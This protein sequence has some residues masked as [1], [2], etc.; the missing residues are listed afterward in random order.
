MLASTASS[1]PS[2]GSFSPPLEDNDDLAETVRTFLLVFG[3]LGRMPSGHHQRHLIHSSPPSF[4]PLSLFA[5]EA[6]TLDYPVSKRASA[7]RIESSTI[8]S[9]SSST[10]LRSPSANLLLFIGTPSL[11]PL[12]L[13]H[14]PGPAPDL[15]LLILGLSSCSRGQEHLAYTLNG[16]PNSKEFKYPRYDSLLPDS[17]VPH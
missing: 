12:T 8:V 3:G 10:P 16:R 2:S 14:R 11:L 9:T 17:C 13:L 6:S 1:P 15:S 7:V 5:V 4:I